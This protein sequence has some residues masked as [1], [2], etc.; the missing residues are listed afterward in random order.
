MIKSAL[1]L[2]LTLESESS[3]KLKENKQSNR[4]GSAM[5][6]GRELRFGRLNLEDN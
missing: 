4:I 3:Q 1:M 5:F 6:I 2:I